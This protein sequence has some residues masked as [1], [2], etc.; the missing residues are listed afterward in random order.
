MSRFRNP[1]FLALD[2]GDLESALSLARKV[3]PHV[4]GYK[5]GLEMF[6]TAGPAGIEPIAE[7]GLPIFIDL[8]FHDIPNT[9]AGAVRSVM[10]LK[11]A[12]LTVHCSGG[13]EMLRAAAETVANEAE[14][15]DMDA[16]WLVGVT[17]LT[18][19]D[20]G[21]LD[22]LGIEG[23][24][25]KVVARL[26]RL[27][28]KAGLDGIVCA[29]HEI[30]TAR[31]TIGSDL[32]L[33]VPGIRPKGSDTGDQKRVMTPREAVSLGADI[34]VIGRPISRADDPVM[35]VNAILGSLGE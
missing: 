28:E 2:S 10:R 19:L 32:K 35:A 33:I 31:S 3:A 7:I 23:S 22:A 29:P 4:G 17:V 34:L 25:H 30:S 1:L 21:D 6:C 13:L 9:V 11:P 27:A 18:S 14:R 15:Q 12:I 16:P 8:K 24:T 26:A 5:I 20:A